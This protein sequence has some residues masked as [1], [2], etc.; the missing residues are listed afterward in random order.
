MLNSFDKLN[1]QRFGS[2]TSNFGMS[3]PNNANIGNN[4]SPAM[5]AQIDPQAIKDA[6][7]DNFI[8][9]RI[10]AYDEVD[11]L[12]QLGLSLPV[13]V[14]INA[15]MDKY[16]KL[17]DGDYANSLPGRLGNFG[18]KVSNFVTETPV[19][20]FFGGVKNRIQPY[21]KKYVY[22]KSAIIRALDKTPTSPELKFVKNQMN[23]GTEMAMSSHIN[24][25]ENFLKPITE[26]KDLDSLGASKVDIGRIENR[27][28]NAA[29]AE[30]KAKIMLEEQFK[31]LKEGVSTEELNNFK[32]L[33]QE[34]KEALIKDL[35]V[36]G[37]SGL[38]NFAEF[39]ALK[40][41]AVK[42]S[43]RFFEAAEKA[44]PKFFT[45]IDWSDKNDY[46]KLKGWLTGRK[47]S[48][49]QSR[50]I[51]IS[52]AGKAN[53]MHKTAL[54]RQ[55]SKWINLAT[56]GATGRMFNGKVSTIMQAFFVAEALLMASKQES[57]GDKLKSFAERLIELIG[58][59]VFAGP[60]IKLMHKVGGMRYRG[61]TPKQVEELKKE[62]QELN[63]KTAEGF[64][65]KKKDWKIAKK[66]IK[67]KYFTKTK[68]PLVWFARK[69]GDFIDTGSK[70]TT[71]R[72]W[73]RFK[74]KDA[75]MCITKLFSK[76][77]KQ[78]LKNIPH[79]LKDIACNPKYWG[80]RMA[81]YPIR[82]AIPMMI[83]LPFF[84]KIAVKI[85][86]TIFG[87]PKYSMLDESKYEKEQEEAKVKAEQE[88]MLTAI[89]AQQQKEQGQNPAEQKPRDPNSY[90]SDTNLIKMTAN[91]QKIP[92]IKSGTNNTNIKIN[93]KNDEP[94]R[95]YIPDPTNFVT[96]NIDTSGLDN[97]FAKAD[98]TEQ[99][100]Q[101]VL[102]MR[103]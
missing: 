79:R 2:M 17:Y 45:R 16:L 95:T 82:F 53:I 46:T 8:G 44:N 37:F 14:A 48:T 29:N 77:F 69:I 41:D 51:L 33:T 90:T 88:A 85:G 38:D 91:G 99:E 42:N 40:Q 61:L 15:G 27:L 20:K 72:P 1:N 94:V 7:E 70:E 60:S 66:D 96:N 12:T 76:D 80:K 64:F 101:N 35:K 81:G 100:I 63:K 83:I 68:N 22:D 39:E 10:K 28:K 18:D 98:K 55:L 34:A 3:T 65:T 78:Y 97:A 21:W 5:G 26:V 75:D 84:N 24:N 71:F 19:G 32:N 47:V 73:S 11:Q 9:N 62:I 102:K 92:E 56:E 67:A 4:P 59:F 30:D 23:M 58:F 57:T 43:K 86:H 13:A 36:K 74:H 54:G 6:A 87:K 31:L 50:N 89:A 93:N 52:S 25:I 49:Q 103:Y